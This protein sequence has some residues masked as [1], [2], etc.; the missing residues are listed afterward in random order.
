M[1][2]KTCTLQTAGKMVEVL[3]VVIQ[4]RSY[5]Y[6][7][8]LLGFGFGFWATP[9]GPESLLLALHLGISSSIV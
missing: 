3:M 4:K 6:I 7:L 2:Y 9:S 1:E 8:F 5:E